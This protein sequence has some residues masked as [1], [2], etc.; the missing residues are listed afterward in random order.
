MMF[1]YF[2]R[3]ILFDVGSLASMR[4]KLT[5]KQACKGSTVVAKKNIANTYSDTGK[6]HAQAVDKGG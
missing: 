4:K 5:I 6:Y 2:T 3:M 1:S